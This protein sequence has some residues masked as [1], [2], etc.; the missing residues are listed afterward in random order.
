M[1]KPVILGLVWGLLLG[2]L[3]HAQTYVDL[4]ESI[5]P[6]SLA[7]AVLAKQVD[8]TNQYRQS[9]KLARLLSEFPDATEVFV[10]TYYQRSADHLLLEMSK[11]RVTL[12]NTYLVSEGL[13]TTWWKLSDG[14]CWVV[15]AQLTFLDKKQL[16]L[17]DRGCIE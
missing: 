2:S 16:A 10:E 14:H 17:V 15:L 4:T 6:S 11:G 7:P 5:D 13:G 12:K 8:T 3:L 1:R 9:F